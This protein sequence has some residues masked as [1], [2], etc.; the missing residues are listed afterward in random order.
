MTFLGLPICGILNA[1]KMKLSPF[2]LLLLLTTPLLWADTYTGNCVGVTDGDTISVMH[3]G[4]AVKIRLEGID[5]PEAGQD[6]GTRAKQF[7][8]GLVFGKQV[9]VKEYNLDRYGQWVEGVYIEGRDVF[10]DLVNAL[11]VWHHCRER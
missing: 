1:G 7:T 8:S 3:S 11:P 4:R 2:L 9:Y 6:I 10:L 5:C